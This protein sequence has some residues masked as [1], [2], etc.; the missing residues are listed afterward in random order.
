MK[1]LLTMNMASAKGN[2]VHQLTVEHP[3]E[4]LGQFRKVLAGSD[5]IICTLLYRSNDEYTQNSWIDRGDII[6]NT[7]LVGKAQEYVDFYG[8]E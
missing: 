3:A 8:G 1:Y 5:Y 7:S 4:D 6:I 2:P